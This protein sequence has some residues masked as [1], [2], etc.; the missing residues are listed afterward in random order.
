[1][2]TDRPHVQCCHLRDIKLTMK[3]PQ[4]RNLYR[5]APMVVIVTAT[6]RGV[7]SG[8]LREAEPSKAA[9]GL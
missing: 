4:S 7:R 5:V 9:L 8:V 1:M 3:S 2:V 6:P